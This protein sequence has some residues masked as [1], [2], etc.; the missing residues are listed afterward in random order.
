MPFLLELLKPFNLEPF[1]AVL[2]WVLMNLLTAFMAREEFP[3]GEPGEW[4]LVIPISLHIPCYCSQ[5][6]YMCNILA[7]HFF[8]FLSLFPF[9]LRS[10]YLAAFVS[11]N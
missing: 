3:V 5:P 8:P 2:L 9:R 10:L 6:I 4:T 1:Q 7:L 11:A